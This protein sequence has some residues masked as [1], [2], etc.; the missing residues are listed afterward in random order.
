MLASVQVYSI[1][2]PAEYLGRPVMVAVQPFSSLR[3]TVWPSERVTSRLSGRKPSWFSASS[4]T[5]LTVAS[6]SSG[7]WLLVSVVTVPSL[8]VP[9]SS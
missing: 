2:W 5:F 9:V 1:S 4:Q 7:V 8:E 6:V 3:V